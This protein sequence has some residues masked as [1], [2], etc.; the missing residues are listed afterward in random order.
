MLDLGLVIGWSFSSSHPSR[1]SR[2]ASSGNSPGTA[3]SASSLRRPF[4]THCTAAMPVNSFVQDATVST[5]SEVSGSDAVRSG[6]LD[7]TPIAWEYLNFPTHVFFLEAE[8]ENCSAYMRAKTRHSRSWW[9]IIPLLSAARK[10]PPGT[11]PEAMAVER[12]SSKEVMMVDTEKQSKGEI[13]CEWR[14]RKYEA[15]VVRRSYALFL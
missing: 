10:T 3:T 8:L 11:V 15:P 12:F 7:R 4:S 5:V 9:E 2:L 13:D 14:W 1:I 6:L